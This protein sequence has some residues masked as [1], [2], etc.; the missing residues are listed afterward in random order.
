MM[1]IRQWG[2]ISLEG[3]LLFSSISEHSLVSFRGSCSSAT[4][5]IPLTAKIQ[6]SALFY[7]FH[8]H[9]PSFFCITYTV[10][11]TKSLSAPQ[12]FPCGRCVYLGI[13]WPSSTECLKTQAGCWDQSLLAHR[14][15]LS[16][17]DITKNTIQMNRQINY[18]RNRN[19]KYMILIILNY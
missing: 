7:N 14:S 6:S 15:P 16:N 19:L 9:F 17:T 18:T 10:I 4:V 2:A 12:T 3:C 5:S 13:Y 8:A 11:T 1:Q